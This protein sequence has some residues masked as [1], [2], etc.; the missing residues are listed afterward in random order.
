MALVDTLRAGGRSCSGVAA[1]LALAGIVTLFVGV[2]F[3][4]ARWIGPPGGAVA[5]DA[6]GGR[7]RRAA[8]LARAARP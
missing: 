6:A 5:F 8:R 3:A 4:L 7:D 2:A 1:A